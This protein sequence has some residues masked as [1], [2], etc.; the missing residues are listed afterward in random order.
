MGLLDFFKS[1]KEFIPRLSDNSIELQ[2]KRIDQQDDRI[3]EQEEKIQAIAAK[4]KSISKQ[5]QEISE[6]RNKCIVTYTT[7]DPNRL[8]TFRDIIKIRLLGKDSDYRYIATL[9]YN[10]PQDKNDEIVLAQFNKGD[11]KTIKNMISDLIQ[12][13]ETASLGL[14]DKERITKRFK[15]FKEYAVE[16]EINITTEGEEILTNDQKDPRNIMKSVVYIG[17]D[18]KT[19]DPKYLEPEEE[20][21]NDFNNYTV[22][23][24]EFMRKTKDVVNSAVRINN[25][26]NY[27]VAAEIGKDELDEFF[28]KSPEFY[29]EYRTLHNKAKEINFLMEIVDYI[30]ENNKEYRKQ[31]KIAQYFETLFNGDEEAAK[32]YYLEN[33]LDISQI[34]P[35]IEEGDSRESIG[36]KLNMARMLSCKHNENIG[37]ASEEER[38]SFYNFLDKIQTKERYKYTPY[39]QEEMI[40]LAGICDRVKSTGVENNKQNITKYNDLL[41]RQDFD[42]VVSYEVPDDDDN[43]R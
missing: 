24:Q 3:R 38:K 11:L 26:N 19:I 13:Q 23:E 17:E 5:I 2:N 4:T 15:E 12:Y 8:I 20:I 6:S 43:V 18:N 32:R 34:K 41:R 30:K 21:I 22:E 1:K 28:K 42:E 29:E 36:K 33:N 25:I 7:Y 14:L 16:N 10:S 27:R 37:A 9:L 40:Y 39:N 31:P 35:K